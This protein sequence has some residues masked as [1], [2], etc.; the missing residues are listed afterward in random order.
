[1]SRP[2]SGARGA[3]GAQATVTPE[4]LAERTAVASAA[5]AAGLTKEA[6]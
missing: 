2:V 4:P 1:M 6:L 3:A 5:G